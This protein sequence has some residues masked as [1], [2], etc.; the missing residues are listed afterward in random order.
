M[1]KLL[2]FNY[3]HRVHCHRRLQG[4]VWRASLIRAGDQSKVEMLPFA[5]CLNFLE[6]SY[7]EDQNDS[8][9]ALTS[10]REEGSRACWMQDGGSEASSQPGLAF[11]PS[12]RVLSLD[13]FLE[14][15]GFRDT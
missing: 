8:L 11:P 3:G 5:I 7:Y 4:E 10:W 9:A 6:S 13:L 12:F 14:L 2:S 15:N 1:T